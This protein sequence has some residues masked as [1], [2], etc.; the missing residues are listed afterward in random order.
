MNV[1]SE[2]AQRS[3]RERVKY[4]SLLDRDLRA[5]SCRYCEG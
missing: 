5:S 1:I 4:I 2:L 3:M